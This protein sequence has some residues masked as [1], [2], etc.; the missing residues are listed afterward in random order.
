MMGQVVSLHI[1]HVLRQPRVVQGVVHTVVEHVKRECASD[2]TVG[3]GFGKDEMGQFGE[4]RF[5]DEK[6][7]RW[8]D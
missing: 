5:E 1:R 4:R 8:H 2:D 3:D 7:C 6:E